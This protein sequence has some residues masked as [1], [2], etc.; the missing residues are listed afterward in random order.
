M[1]NAPS[2]HHVPD[3]MPQNK[4]MSELYLLET[5]ARSQTCYIHNGMVVFSGMSKCKPKSTVYVSL[6]HCPLQFV[7]CDPPV[8]NQ[9]HSILAAAVKCASGW[10]CFFTERVVSPKVIGQTQCCMPCAWWLGRWVLGGGV[11]PLL[12]QMYWL[13]GH[14]ISVSLGRCPRGHLEVNHMESSQVVKTGHPILSGVLR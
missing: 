1:L 4:Y 5:L 7:A 12:D 11:G 2:V 14:Q 8:I 3:M 13:S 9:H 10:H 6:A